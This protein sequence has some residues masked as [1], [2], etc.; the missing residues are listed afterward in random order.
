MN[1]RTQC[2]VS[3]PPT[4]MV[5][6]RTRLV[7]SSTGRSHV[8]ARSRSRSLAPRFFNEC[9]GLL[10]SCDGQL[11][12]VDE[13]DLSEHAGLI[14][15][16]MLVGDFVPF[17]FHHDNMRQRYFPPGRRNTWKYVINRAVVRKI[18]DELVHHL[19]PAHRPRDP[20]DACIGRHL[21]DEVVR[22][23]IDYTSVAVT[24]DERGHV[25][26]IRFRHHGLHCGGDIVINELMPD[27]SIKDRSYSVWISSTDLPSPSSAAMMAPVEVP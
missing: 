5:Q 11:A 1:S 19:V 10:G 15:V 20:L 18:Y 21:A 12:W 6:V 27:M 8:L 16:D 3:W 14:P 2:R 4:S 13:T 9:L 7:S 24:A 23:K 26:H 25:V 17:K 22:V